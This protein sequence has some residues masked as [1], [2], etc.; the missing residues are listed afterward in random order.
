[1]YIARRKELDLDTASIHCND[2]VARA[3]QE[4]AQSR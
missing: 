4:E 3:D 1:M 2:N